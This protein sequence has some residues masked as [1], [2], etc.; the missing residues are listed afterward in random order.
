[1]NNQFANVSAAVGL[2]MSSTILLAQTPAP[3]SAPAFDPAK[4]R[5]EMEAFMKMPDTV[6]TGKFPAL[7]EEVASLPDH[8]IYRP[9]DLSKLGK[10]KLGL[11]A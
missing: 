4:M 11:L 7:K 9:T 10:E 3:S 6:G 5:A 8:V 2:L 1:M